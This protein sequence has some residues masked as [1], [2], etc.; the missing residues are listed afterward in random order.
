MPV[1]AP[2]SQQESLRPVAASPSVGLPH[3]LAH[4]R[5]TAEERA[6][7]A[8]ARTDVIAAGCV[9]ERLRRL[10]ERSRRLVVPVE[11]DDVRRKLLDELGVI[12][13][14]VA[15][16]HERLAARLQGLVQLQH[17]V[18]IDAPDA[19]L[20]QDGRAAAVRGV[21]V[22]DLVAA[23]VRELRRAARQQHVEESVQ[24][25]ERLRIRRTEVMVSSRTDH[26]FSP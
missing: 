19:L 2:V 1:V 20:A 9:L 11:R 16:E 21:Q 10:R 17:E 18:E 15:P 24:E 26:S 13:D 14:D 22:P 23:E 6:P 8:R 4:V 5:V 7:A 3:V 12:P 25:R